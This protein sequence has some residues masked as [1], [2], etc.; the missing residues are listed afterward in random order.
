MKKFPNYVAVKDLPGD[1][2]EF[3]VGSAESCATR[4]I[5]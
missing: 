3:K 2:E 5:N 4:D 1:D